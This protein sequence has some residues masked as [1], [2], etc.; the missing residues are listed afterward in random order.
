[1][2]PSRR[3]MG[4]VWSRLSFASAGSVSWWLFEPLADGVVDRMLDAL[5]FQMCL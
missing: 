2:K 5:T 1:M 3:I 4:I